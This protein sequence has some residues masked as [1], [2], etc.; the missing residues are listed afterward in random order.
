MADRGDT[1]YH[2]KHLNLWFAFAS[3][4]LLVTAVWMVLDDASRP[5]KNHQREFRALDL[6]R[7]RAELETAELKA[8]AAH[9]ETLQVEVQKAA[10]AV[11]ALNAEIAAKQEVVRLAK[12]EYF[13]KES[14][15]K[16]EKA[17]Y[18]W[19]RYVVD[20]H[21]LEHKDPAYGEAHM[22]A[23]YERMQKSAY[24]KEQAEAA[25][26]KAVADVNALKAPL[27]EAERALKVATKDIELRRAKIEK[28]DPAD[29]ATQVAN[30]V[31]D[32]P[33]L[34]FIGPNLKVQ[35]VA[36]ENLTFELNFTKK[37]R[38]D[39]CQ[40]CHM[41]IDRAGFENAEQP[42]TSHPRLDLFL[43]NKSPH[44]ISEVGCT[45]CHRGCGEALDIVRTD[46]RPTGDEQTK[47]WKDEYHWHKQH[48]WD[49]PMLPTGMS[50]AGCVQCHTD[51]LELIAADA[52]KVTEGYRL[53]EEYGCYAC[54]KV[55]WFPTKR[56]PGPSLK[57]L[58]AKL[59]PEFVASWVADPKAFRPT[60]R[61]P[62]FFNL[63]NFADDAVIAKSKYGEGR[64]V[65]GREW[66]DAAVAAVTAFLQQRHPLQAL[67]KPPAEGDALRGREAFR[68]SGCLGCHNVA[69]HDAQTFPVGGDLAHERADENEMGPNLRGVA[70]KLD[71]DWLYWW[72]K[73]PAKYWPD[74]RMPNLRLSD[75]DAADITA[76]LMEDPD[77]IFRDVPQ[78]W[79]TSIPAAKLDVLQE[80][81]R[82]FF[83]R[84]GR[85]AL[86]QRFEGKDETRRWDRQADL[87]VAVGER[88][89]VQYGCYSCHEVS[90][91][92]SMM[93]IGAE[94]TTWASKTVD[95]L[96]FGFIPYI[97]ADT[98]GWDQETTSNFKSY[99]NNFLEQ[100]LKA[101]RSYDRKKI[102]NPTEK[103]RMPYFGF[104]EE[105]TQA[106]TTFVVG[107]V[108]DEV[109][110]AKMVPDAGE[111]ARDA[112]LR[113][114]R[115]NNCA[116][117]HV[118]EP[119]LVTFKDEAGKLHTVGAEFRKLEGETL[120]PRMDR[121]AEYWADYVAYMKGEDEDF[122]P[123]E[124]EFSLR[125]L[126]PE[127]DFGDIGDSIS[128]L[129]KD[130][131]S[132]KPPVGG[133]LVR[134]VTDWYKKPFDAE[135][136]SRTPDPEGGVG[137][138]DGKYRKYAE[139]EYDKVRWTFAPP[140]LLGE[141]DKLQRNWFY[142]FLNDPIT[143]RH[144]MR[145]RMPSFHYADGEA[146][147]IADYFAYEAQRDWPVYYA[148]KL[149]LA[150][151]KSLEE[152]AALIKIPAETLAGIE[153]GSRP[154]IDAS[155]AKVKAWG[156]AQKFDEVLPPVDPRHERVVRR[157]PAHV[158]A[159]MAAD[160]KHLAKAENLARDASGPYCVQCHY[161]NGQGPAGGTAQPIQ[162]APDLN[163]TA[164][165]LR[166]DWVHKWIENPAK[167]Y[168]GTAMPVN[169]PAD[170]DSHQALFPGKAAVQIQALLDWLYNMQ[171][172]D[173]P[174]GM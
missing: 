2:I 67:P 150:Q 104:T 15:A 87:Q 58:L 93:P 102:K 171:R 13:V 5:W 44:P 135:D 71:A 169:F 99:H 24:G 168:P 161:L 51:S 73:D 55:E 43:T 21:R 37:K 4:A 62:Q 164:E 28:L 109:Q 165:R 47:E 127:P 63:E 42:Y 8:Q 98:H 68:L 76:Y 101:P 52:P 174:T 29:R 163:N 27:K 121:W 100:K 65:L 130:L 91:M 147:A 156:D 173:L 38:I 70:T 117:C 172:Q 75:E 1:H 153:N 152:L 23:V 116:A 59:T 7:T 9:G 32:F 69:P 53:F 140:V 113:A 31:R 125:L 41:G 50:E 25:L 19:E 120:P 108:K 167:V 86:E 36:L 148:R 105:Q 39:M 128:V 45:I 74:T 126:R 78:G 142:A 46:H 81:A 124:F 57:N 159:L 89:V 54:H 154:D 88:F 160:S 14:A 22:A 122:D 145:V 94:L 3:L 18:D 111:L 17:Q 133:D 33:G 82:W 110:R 131:V 10:A 118:L 80:Q 132:V 30:I 12:G 112:G 155:F 136:N 97:F 146:G 11:E 40:S 139:E 157:S 90:G 129:A 61:M 170:K 151:K 137:D 84:D 119:G 26:A 166:E 123:D 6:E 60:T 115:Q 79:Q 95:K 16:T 149:R 107:L 141:G 34:D 77:G 106:I 114:V 49:Y 64:D 72:L 83:T 35:K 85:T 162:W 138:V 158:N 20:E 143:L 96:D 144:Q 92:E 103:L 56:K 134:V 48:H 66:N